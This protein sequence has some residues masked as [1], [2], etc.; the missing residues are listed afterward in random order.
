MHLT[1]GNVDFN[2]LRMIKTICGLQTQKARKAGK[3]GKTILNLPTLIAA[4][5]PCIQQWRSAGIRADPA[6]DK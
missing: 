2:S 5:A 3:G 4:Y 6:A 1:V